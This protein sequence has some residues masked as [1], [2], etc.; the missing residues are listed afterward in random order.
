M[1]QTN[2]E[3]KNDEKGNAAIR[4]HGFVFCHENSCRANS[5]ISLFITSIA[6]RWPAVY[7]SVVMLKIPFIE[8]IVLSLKLQLDIAN[9]FKGIGQDFSVLLSVQMEW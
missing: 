3:R 2:D 7:A 5:E 6:T 9:G 8:K 4:F 1:Q